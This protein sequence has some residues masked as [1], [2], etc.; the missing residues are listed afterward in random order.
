MTNPA[1]ID[2][3][4]ALKTAQHH[5]NQREFDQ[6]QSLC[7]QVLGIAP[8]TPGAF[9]LLALIADQQEKYPDA[10]QHYQRV[11]QLQPDN[12]TAYN[13]LGNA[14][15]R[16]KNILQ[17]IPCYQKAIALKPNNA[18]AYSN[19]GVAYQ[20]LGRYEEA[21][22]AY[23]QGIQVEPTYPHTYYNLGKSFQSQDRLEEAI[24]T[25]QRC[26]QIDPSYAMA[27]NNMG[28]AF[29]DLG[30]VEPSLRAYE[31]ALEIDPSYA[32]GH[33][34]YSL[35]LL[36]AGNYA[37][38]WQEYEWRWRAKGPDNRPPRPFTQ[39]I[40]DGQDLNGK[41]ILI[42]SEQGFGDT[43]QFVRYA[44]IAAAKGGRVIVECQGPLVSLV[45]TVPGV[46][47]VIPRGADLPDFDT[48]AATLSLPYILKTT[49]E[50]IPNQVPYLRADVVSLPL[51]TPQKPVR[52]KVGIAWAGSPGNR[53]DHRRSCPLHHWLPLFNLPDVEFYNLYKG[54]RLREMHTLFHE[55]KVQNLSE[56][57]RTFADTAALM[58]QL[59]LII[60][61]DSSPVHLAGALG[62]PAWLLLSCAS[63]WRWLQNRTDSPWYPT[64]RMFRQARSQDWD[65]VMAEVITALKRE[66]QSV[67]L[68]PPRPI[69]LPTLRPTTTTPPRL[70]IGISWE[71]GVT[72]G[73]RVYGLN[74]TLALLKTET[75]WPLPL[76]PLPEPQA[77]NPLHRT[78]IEPTLQ[79]QTQLR[80]ILSQH[81]A[82]EILQ[83]NFVC[84]HALG[85]N[86]ASLPLMERLRGQ[87]NIGVIF[88]E[89]T[90]WETEA[91]TKANRYDQIVAGSGWNQEI[92]Q[93]VG[94]KNVTTVHQGIDPTLFHPAPKAGLF[95]EK[96][97]IFSGGKLEY[98]KGQDIVIAAFREFLACHSDALLVT[99]W[100]NPWPKTMTEIERAGHVQGIPTL[101][102]GRLDVVGWLAENGIPP[103]AVVDIG[104]VPNPQMPPIYR[105][106]DVAIFPNRGEGGT[107]LVAMECLACG[108]PT[109]LSANTGHLDLIGPLEN[110]THC[111]PLKTQ[112]PV[113][114]TAQFRGTDGW[115][116]SEVAEIIYHL[117]TI[118]Q[119]RSEAQQRGQAAAKF[120]TDWAWDKQTKRLLQVIQGLETQ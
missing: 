41:T 4:Q 84:L 105:E 11:I 52:L 32:N 45:R 78:L 87:A 42:H 120:M 117:E 49:V 70:A 111:Y 116:E 89:D 61:V 104:A 63:D 65:T 37:Q 17:A 62:K 24:L 67:T 6:A 83:A 14:L 9:Y 27:Y 109:I 99:A 97:V 79:P 58:A 74:L 31:K 80:S 90:A 66:L 10:I 2:I 64:V 76:T 12:P 19:L 13:D 38:G 5:L 28:L 48:H 40:W 23:R 113:T 82:N 98:R 36:L 85:N 54:P 106:A 92:L 119:N 77:L 69:S 59:D 43:I 94:I 118:Y 47:A 114:P 88:S 56:R 112:A 21:Q 46:A 102:N 7:Q 53:N 68:P 25:Y 103:Q 96:F 86:C 39:P 20:D 29:Y 33:Q 107:N 51:P 108:V 30:Q 75:H 50:T 34:N 18:Q 1:I 16:S 73:W 26:I 93:S 95:A 110:P 115:G 72:T 35:A 57:M 71:I 81:P 3:P 44:T 55:G 15:Q 101:K 8:H 91:V 22:A 100:H 60:S